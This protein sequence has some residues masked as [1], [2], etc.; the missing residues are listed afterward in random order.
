MIILNVE[1]RL[2]DTQKYSF[3]ACIHVGKRFFYIGLI[4]LALFFLL[5]II[6]K[7]QIIQRGS[8]TTATNSGTNI[9]TLSINT[10]TGV[11]PGDVLIVSILQNETDND[12][13]GLNDVFASGWILVDGRIIHSTG[14]SNNNDAWRGTVLYRI[15]DGTEGA[16]VSFS[17][18]NARADMAIGSMLAF[19]GVHATGGVRADGTAGGPFDIDPGTLNLTNAGTST[20]PTVTTVTPNA[21]VLML[22]M[23]NNDRTFS[24]WVATNPASLNELYDFVT[25]DVDDGALG[26]A[27][28]VRS[29]AGA[30]GAGTVTLSASDRSGALFLVLRPCPVPT[31][32]GAITLPSTICAGST[33][34]VFSISSVAGVS[35][36]QWSVTGTGW[37]ITAGQG[38]TSATITIGSGL[39]SVSVSTRGNCGS[40][41]SPISTGSITP[42]FPTVNVGAALSAICANGTTTGLGGSVGGSATGGIWTDGGIGGTFSP[43]ATTLNATYTPPLNF[44]GTVTLTLTTT[45]G[46]CSAVSSSKS[47]T[48]NPTPN[49]TINYSSSSFCNSVLTAQDVTII[50]TSGGTFSAGAGLNI[51]P[52]NGAINPSL[53]NAGVYTVTYTVAASGGCSAFNTSITVTIINDA[54]SI[55]YP[56]LSYCANP[57]IG[58]VNVTRNAPAGGSYTSTPVGLSLN[59]INGSIDPGA[60][61]PG[62]YQVI[63]TFSG[64]TCSNTVSTNVV[65][66]AQPTVVSPANMGACIS[67]SSFQLTGAS[68][69]GGS[70]SGPGVSGGFFNPAT[71]GVGTHIITY[72]YTNASGCTA[73]ST[74]TIT[75]SNSAPSV[76]AVPTNTYVYSGNFVNITLNG[77]IPGTQYTWTATTNN[78]SI[79]GFS[80]QATSVP[81]PIN[82]QV[83]NPSTSVGEITYVITPRL[84]GCTGTPVTVVI[85][86]PSSTFCESPGTFQ[87]GSCIIDMGVKPQSYNNGIKPYGLVYQLVNVYKVPVYW[88]I[89]TN[90]TFTNPWPKSD[91]ADFTLDGY[92][93]R[94]GPFII[95]AG[96]LSQVQSVINSWVAQGVVVRYA[97]TSFTPPY[98]DLVSRI[99]KVVL[100]AANGSLIQSGFY[101][102]A[103]IPAEA[104]T[105][106]GIPSAITN[107]DDIYVLPHAEPQNWTLAQR[108][109]LWNFINNRGWFFGSCYA[110][111]FI[112]NLTASGTRR[113]NFLSNNGLIPYNQH[114][115]PTL[116]YAYSTGVGLETGGIAADPFM[117]FVDTVD[118]AINND[119]AFEKIYVPNAAGWRSTTKVAIYKSN[120]TNNSITY[121][122]NAAILAYG[123]AFGDNTKG[124]IMYL[125]GHDFESG[126]SESDN[127]AKAR[128]YASFLLRAGIGTRPRIEPVSIPSSANSGQSVTVQVSIPPTTSPIASTEWVSD[129]NGIFSSNNTTATFIAPTVDVPT[130]CTIQFKVTD[131][132]GRVGLYCTTILINPTITNNYISNAQTICSG[133]APNLMTGTLPAGPAG[134]SPQ[135]QWLVSTTSASAGYANAPGTSNQ[136]NYISPALTQTSWFRRQ[137]TMNGLVVFSTPIQITVSAGPA[138]TSQPSANA[139]GVCQ[140]GTFTSIS[141]GTSETGVGYQWYSNTVASNVGGSPISGATAASFTP[142]SAIQGTTYYYSVLTNSVG[143]TATSAVSG[144]INVNASLLITTQP[145]TTPQN[146]C[147]GQSFTPLTVI[148]NG[149]GLTYQWYSNI[150]PANSGGS[151]ISGATGA[152]YTPPAGT[153]FYYYVIVGSPNGG[154]LPAAARSQVSALMTIRTLPLPQIVNNSGTNTITCETR[155]ISL[156]ASGGTTYQWNGGQFNTSTIAATDSGVYTVSVTGANGCSASSSI[157]I[158]WGISGSTWTG[159]HDADW[160]EDDN[161]CG[162]IPGPTSSVT[163]PAGTP[164]DPVIST[165][166]ASVKDL[167]ILNGAVV[168][169]DGQRLKLYGNLT[170]TGNINAVNGTLELCGTNGTQSI[171][172][173]M[174]AAKRIQNLRLS[175]SNGIDLA[176]VNDSLFITGRLD[177]GSSDV[178]FNTNG[179]LVMKSDL[180]ATAEVA[181]MTQ[182]GQFSNNRIVGDITVERYIP[183][184]PK[185]WQL[186]AAPTSGKTVRQTW[187]EGNVSADT[188]IGNNRPGYGTMI[189][190]AAGGSLSGAQALGFDL[191]TPV[192]ATIKTYNPA[193]SSWVNMGTTNT[194]INSQKGYML[195]VRGD[196]SVTRF[197]QPS[198]ATTLRTTGTLY[199]PIGNAPQSISIMANRMECIGNPYASAVD[200]SKLTRAGGVQDVYYIWD[201]TLTTSG[202]SAWGLG[203]YRAIVRSGNDYIAVPASGA[204]STGDIQLQSGQA[205]FARAFNQPGSIQFSETAKGSGSQLV[206]R[207]NMSPMSIRANL[208]VMAATPILLDGVISQLDSSYENA[209]DIADAI[210]LTYGSAE[211][212]SIA[213]GGQ[214]LFAEQRNFNG[215]DTVQ[216]DIRN[217]RRTNYRLEIIPEQLNPAIAEVR[218][219]DRYTGAQLLLSSSDT[220]YYPFVVNTD[221]GSF[222]SNRFYLL[223]RPTA[224]LPVRFTDVYARP[225]NETSNEIGWRVEQE[226]DMDR[227]VVEKSTDGLLFESIGV[228]VLPSNNIGGTAQYQTMDHQAETSVCAY[229]IKA[230]NRDGSSLYSRIV[231]VR[232]S[233]LEASTLQ[234][235]PNPVLD[236]T[237]HIHLTNPL[238]GDYSF[239]ITDVAGKSVQQFTRKIYSSGDHNLALRVSSFMASGQ[240]ILKVIE[241][242]GNLQ[243]ASFIID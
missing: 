79:V 95:P 62:T 226:M 126:V 13:G 109:S 15:A 8:A 219:V 153:S 227:Y 223:F 176:G 105:L 174:F 179:N 213:T 207:D 72:S 137:V 63:Y 77:S 175:N 139:Q 240:Y 100:D 200:F 61:T 131:A 173:S 199:Q 19:F 177:F 32:P 151:L 2:P 96:Y 78:P 216:Y 117:Q 42:V 10:P 54:N 52:A 116:P 229:R 6:S 33:G 167:T 102:R 230:I 225:M 118:R 5:P 21:A 141:V 215:I 1:K 84:T 163:I 133:S 69:A 20:A 90:K 80:A 111:S 89:N 228:P 239:V 4:S 208:T 144:V 234:I 224:V 65:I 165:A 185:A 189:T 242:D 238:P 197:N 140:G 40:V 154:C 55:N 36:Y 93:Y 222:A 158:G 114:G 24:N 41:S 232:K 73:S 106:G 22:S 180:N 57:S 70:Y 186:L 68:P 71:A 120:Y 127:V 66:Y 58:T 190:G 23:V 39:G 119:G 44:S 218:L 37:A 59:G 124:M 113:L 75:V 212:I 145:S 27:W 169:L 201:P 103:G 162:H 104:Y 193:D 182:N 112:E 9:T 60:S 99:P 82:Q 48:I 107:C 74:F 231:T 149:S 172:G 183:N 146:I 220:L 132:C 135:Y 233:K 237:L 64:S 45:G 243:H 123:R 31:G 83:Y 181:D 53:S 184:H 203:G 178:V 85:S 130:V 125:S 76:T 156:T 235:A 129:L 134:F 205:F 194:L 157:V 143:C 35:G 236:K 12:N 81:G 166:I 3:A 86:M 241:P 51:N 221:A 18:P 34:N 209:I 47:L 198:T 150:N 91:P 214:R 7:A 164:N 142:S 159:E 26:A 168:Y 188:T 97:S 206:T 147:V 192:G 128:I 16:S 49:A 217:L 187:Q 196:R 30:T 121:P 136:Q 152:N 191:Y 171:S 161:W 88:A 155:T 211:N 122:T 29:T 28:A 138:I 115:S 210:K 195:F 160:D 204:Y 108:D 67:T 148:A 43:N 25:T 101:N 11:Q 94:G 87:A 50:G 98:Y 14:T 202:F 38:T 17:L 56:A 110:V 170:S 46:T 92:T